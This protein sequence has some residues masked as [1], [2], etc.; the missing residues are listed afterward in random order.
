WAMVSGHNLSYLWILSRTPVMDK[1][2]LERLLA[3]AHSKG[4]DTLKVI[5]TRQLAPGM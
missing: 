5:R 4:F 2:L 1:V 3:E